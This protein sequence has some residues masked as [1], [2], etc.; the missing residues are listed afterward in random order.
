MKSVILK[1]SVTT[2]HEVAV[3]IT[4]DY[5]DEPWSESLSKDRLKE[6]IANA[7]TDEINSRSREEYR[8]IKS[9]ELDCIEIVGVEFEGT[10]YEEE[11]LA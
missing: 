9:D 7:V 4:P 1:L 6:Q 3:P 11:H 10:N 5:P 8:A 2:R